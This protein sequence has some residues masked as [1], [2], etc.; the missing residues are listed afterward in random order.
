[1][2]RVIHAQ[3]ALDAM[4]K[5]LSSGKTYLRVEDETCPWN[6]KNFCIEWENGQ[7]EVRVS[8]KQSTD[9]ICSA[10]ALSQLVTGFVP[11]AKQLQSSGL[12]IETLKPMPL[13]LFP[14]KETFIADFF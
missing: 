4:K 9:I 2:C 5:P 1:M 10:A 8:Q 7:G 14:R 12:Q 6:Q 3:K 11:L 13:D